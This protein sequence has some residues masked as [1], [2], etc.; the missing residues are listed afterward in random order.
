MF[1]DHYQAF[2][3]S[4]EILLEN[5]ITDF[6]L[7]IIRLIKKKHI[8]LTTVDEYIEFR[9][10]THETRPYITIND[11]RSF[12]DVKRNVYMIVY[13]SHKKQQRIRF[14]LAHE[15]GHIL[16]G[17]LDNELTEIDR[18]G[19][20]NELYQKFED[21][22]DTFAGNL[23]APPIL[24]YEKIKTNKQFV[25]ESVCKHFALSYNAVKYFRQEDFF[26]WIKTPPTATEK[27]ILYN[28]RNRIHPL[29]CNFCNTQI[30]GKNF[31]FCPM[32][33]KKLFKERYDS[34]MT[35]S[36]IELDEHMKAQVCPKCQ[37][38][39]ILSEGEYCHICGSILVNKCQQEIFDGD[40]G[41]TV[42]PCCDASERLP[43][44]AR[45]CPY[46]GSETTF[47]QQGILKPWDNFIL[48]PPKIQSSYNTTKNDNSDEQLPF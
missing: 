8:L 29:H 47:L 24:I 32:C 4:Q 40:F 38:E 41:S 13:N 3:K 10:Y 27:I 15:L 31:E 11:G 45:Y 1:T 43:G 37:N 21:E 33:G 17:H 46:C 16:L 2:Q 22:A 9:K 20:S 6:P 19:I 25:V 42:A 39:E 34:S 44:S 36:R 23:L 5:T 12:Y 26:E 28:Y 7:D 48:P 18:G 14:T 35:Y 30:F